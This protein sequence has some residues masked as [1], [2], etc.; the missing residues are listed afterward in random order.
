VPKTKHDGTLSFEQIEELLAA[1]A[2]KKP[3]RPM[4]RDQWGQLIW[5]ALW[6]VYPAG[7]APADIREATGLDTNQLLAGVRYL[8][9]TVSD[10][11][12]G[13]VVYVR[14]DRLWY[15]ASTWESHARQAIREGFLQNSA[16]LLHSA[17]QL[18]GQARD[19]FPAYASR[20]EDVIVTA[21]YLQTM[22]KRLAQDL[23]AA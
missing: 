7:L 12:H 10:D 3:G 22:T 6:A 1:D 8:R 17:E 20:I 4:L 19:A 2:K 15:I 14:G 21:D 5:D 9:S 11:Q 16:A 18:L 23:S 13:P